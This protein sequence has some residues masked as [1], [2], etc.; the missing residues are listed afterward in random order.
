MSLP[1]AIERLNAHL[2]GFVRAYTFQLARGIQPQLPTG[3]ADGAD[4]PGH[5]AALLAARAIVRTAR[6]KLDVR[7]MLSALENHLAGLGRDPSEPFQRLLAELGDGGEPASTPPAVTAAVVV[8]AVVVEPPPP[9]AQQ[10]A[11]VEAEPAAPTVLPSAPAPVV[12]SVEAVAEVHPEPS[13]PAES[14]RT[15]PETAVEEPASAEAAEGPAAV[16]P[17]E[18]LSGETSSEHSESQP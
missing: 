15:E 9:A 17:V 2:I 10:A 13:S 5:Q 4:A 7:R 16:V 14:V 3:S 6:D 8:P 1:T 12:A 18:D 11:V